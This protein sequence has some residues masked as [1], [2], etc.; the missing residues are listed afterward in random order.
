MKKIIL[1]LSLLLTVA[2]TTAV[3]AAEPGIN[4]QVKESFKKEFAGAELIRW[5]DAGD[6]VKATFI[7]RGYRTEAYFAQDGQLEGTVRSLFYNQ[8]PLAVMTSLDKRYATADII[9]VT[10]ITNGNGTAYRVTVEA[11]GKKFRVR[12]DTAGNITDIERLKK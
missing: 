7:L 8:L 11:N 10:E 9:D 3:A 12:I 1:S 6:Y 5:A 4:E 2:V